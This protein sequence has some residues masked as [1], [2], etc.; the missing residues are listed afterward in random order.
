MRFDDEMPIDRFDLIDSEGNNHRVW[1]MQEQIDT[2]TY[3]EP[4]HKSPDGKRLVTAD[5]FP[6]K[7][8]DDETFEIINTGER[9]RKV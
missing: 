1:V 9:L 2:S 6:V 3:A 4:N 5:G 8:V 7:Q